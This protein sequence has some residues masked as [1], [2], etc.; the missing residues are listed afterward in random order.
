MIYQGY[1]RDEP[2]KTKTEL[3]ISAWRADHLELITDE[4]WLQLFDDFDDK[5][6]IL[7]YLESL[8]RH[9]LSETEQR[10]GRRYCP[11]CF[12]MDV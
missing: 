3:E 11:E 9:C 8:C 4:W 2:K 1:T 10:K 5:E 7:E 12:S 6:D